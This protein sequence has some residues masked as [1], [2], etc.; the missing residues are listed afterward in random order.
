MDESTY[1]RAIADKMKSRRMGAEEWKIFKRKL[2]NK[3][4][5]MNPNLDTDRVME[6]AEKLRAEMDI[7]D[8]WREVEKETIS[9]RE[10]ALNALKSEAPEGALEGFDVS[11][12]P[13]Y[14]LGNF[15]EDEDEI[16][17]EVK[18]ASGTYNTKVSKETI[19]KA[20][21]VLG[22]S[23]TATPYRLRKEM[24]IDNG[25]SRVI[26]LYL[27]KKGILKPI[28]YTGSKKYDSINFQLKNGQANDFLKSKKR[29]K[30]LIPSYLFRH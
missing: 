21:G 18:R 10:D 17:G 3:M 22:K 12:V 2:K 8:K 16:E 4:E 15:H 26:I 29:V 5:K 1:A 27:W 20:I 30:P 7:E 14:L 9:R 6:K 19:K 11:R 24:G 23:E 28:G 13:P 25:A